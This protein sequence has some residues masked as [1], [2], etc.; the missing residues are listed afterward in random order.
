MIFQL[1]EKAYS[2][3]EKLFERYYLF[4]WI[5]N[6][7]YTLCTFKCA[8]W[9]IKKSGYWKDHSSQQDSNS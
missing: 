3:A 6:I 7:K 8:Q 5:H 1:F 9:I 4:P 2:K